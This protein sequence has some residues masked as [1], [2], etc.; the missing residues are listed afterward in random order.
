M[1]ANVLHRWLKEQR[2]FRPSDGASAEATAIE[3]GRSGVAILYSLA[4]RHET[5]R[6]PCNK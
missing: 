4:V 2:K 5:S 1:N 3:G 6:G